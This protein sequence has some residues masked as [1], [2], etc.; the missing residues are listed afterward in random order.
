MNEINDD[1]YFHALFVLV[2]PYGYL[3]PYSQQN[4][5]Q[6]SNPLTS[7]T[8]IRATYYKAH[9]NTRLYE[10]IFIYLYTTHR[11]VRSK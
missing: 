5:L 11:I 7:K 3:S 8:K 9:Y 6:K 1:I 4:L 10:I 2:Y